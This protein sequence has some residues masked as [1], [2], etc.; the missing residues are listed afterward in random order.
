MKVALRYLRTS[1]ITTSDGLLARGHSVTRIERNA[2]KVPPRSAGQTR[3]LYRL[4]LGLFLKRARTTVARSFRRRS[5]QLAR[6]RYRYKG[7][8]YTTATWSRSRA[9]PISLSPKTWR[10]DFLATAGKSRGSPIQT[11]S[12]RWSHF[13]SAAD[14]GSTPRAVWRKAASAKR[15]YKGGASKEDRASSTGR[16]ACPIMWVHFSAPT[17]AAPSFHEV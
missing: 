10:R 6:R 12:Q 17:P 7:A 5:D 1:G 2:G 4:G 14:S 11:T 8:R 16:D 13:C 9:T 3:D 15:I